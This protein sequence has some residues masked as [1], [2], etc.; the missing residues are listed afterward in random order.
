MPAD[1]LTENCDTGVT[2]T[3]VL[4]R[5]WLRSE[6]SYCRSVGCSPIASSSS[7]STGEPA[8]VECSNT[9]RTVIQPSPVRSTDARA[10]SSVV[11]STMR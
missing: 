3:I 4:K 11:F 10:M 1:P 7:S 6:M 9:P 2:C 8:R 5:F